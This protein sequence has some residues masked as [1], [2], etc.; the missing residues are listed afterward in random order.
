M[1]DDAVNN[2]GWTFSDI[3]AFTGMTVSGVAN[4]RNRYRDTFPK[5]IGRNGVALV[6]DPVDVRNWLD[7]NTTFFDV[8]HT[9][10]TKGSNIPVL[11][12]VSNRVWYHATDDTESYPFSAVAF[13][14]MKEQ[15]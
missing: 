2:L 10:K 6:F 5:P 14:A 12:Y 7:N 15:P 9:E 4:W 1:S 11:A 13:E 8:D 3:A